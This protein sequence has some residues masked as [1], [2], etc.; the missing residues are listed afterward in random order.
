M[1][2][3]SKW[4]PGQDYYKTIKGYRPL[5]ESVKDPTIC[6]TEYNNSG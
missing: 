4:S 2:I 6:G 3:T 5:A 1:E